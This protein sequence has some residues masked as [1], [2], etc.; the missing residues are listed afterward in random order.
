[1]IVCGRPNNNDKGFE[2]ILGDQNAMIFPELYVRIL[3][4]NKNLKKR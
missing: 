2:N 3:V 4:C 1:M